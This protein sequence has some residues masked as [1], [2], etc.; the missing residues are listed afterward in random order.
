MDPEGIRQ[1]F[2]AECGDAPAFRLREALDSLPFP[3]RRYE[4]YF[5]G[6][7]LPLTDPLPK[8]L[9]TTLQQTVGLHL[10]DTIILADIDPVIFDADDLLNM[11]AYVEAG[12]GLL[13]LPG[14]HS[15]SR[16]QRNWGPVR[17]VL[18]ATIELQTQRRSKLWNDPFPTEAIADIVAVERGDPHLITRGLTGPL[19]QVR[20]QEP[21]C[22]AA[23]ASV[24]LRAGTD[25]VALAGTYGRGRVVMVTAIPGDESASLF[26]T[27]AWIDL[28]HQSL[29]W[30][31]GRDADLVIR[32]S[33]LDTA[34]MRPGD[35]R[36]CHLALE[37]ISAA[38]V[39]A[40][41]EISRADPGWAAVGREPQYSEPEVVE[42]ALHHPHSL[43]QTTAALS[44]VKQGSHARSTS[45]RDEG[46]YDEANHG[47]DY[48]FCAASPGLWRLRFV[49]EGPKWANTRIVEIPVRTA[50]HLQLWPET[51]EYSI[52]PEGVLR[53]QLAA[54]TPVTATIRVVDVEGQE[55]W[56]RAGVA[57]GLLA[58]EI[59]NWELGD[60]EVIAATADGE[61]ARLRF[62]VCE[63][64]TTLPFGLAGYLAGNTEERVRWWHD[65]FRSRGFNSFHARLPEVVTGPAVEFRAGAYARYIAQAG[66]AY[67]WSLEGANLIS[68]HGHYG[69]E[70]SQPTNPCVFAPDY[71]PVMRQKLADRFQCGNAVPRLAGIMILDE[72]HVMR[73]NVCRCDRCQEEF[74]RRHS[75][76]LPTWDEA[77][78]AKDGRTRDYFEWVVDY[79]GEAFRRGHQT[80]TRFGPGPRLF[81]NMSAIGSGGINVAHGIAEDLLWTPHTDILT[82][83]CYNYMY[84]YWRGSQQLMWNHFHYLMGHFRFLALRNHQPLGFWIQVTDRD[85][86][87]RPA[88]PLRAPSET[89]YTA[90][91]GGAK[92]F[93]LMYKIPFSNGQNCRE[94]KFEVFAS[95][96]RK[97]N[98]VAPLLERTE[99][100]RSRIA[101]VFPF[102][103]RLYRY[104]QPWLPP[105]HA[106]LGFYTKEWYP[107]DTIWPNHNAPINVAEL[108]VRAFGETDVIDQRALREGA[109]DDY[110]GFVLAG[111]EWM[112][113]RDAIAVRKFVERGGV[114]L[115]DHVPSRTL[116][117]QPLELLAPLFGQATELLYRETVVHRGQFGKGSTLLLSDDLNELYTS[118]IERSDLIL[119]YRLKDLVR[120]F[121]FG[122]G[123]RP[124][125]RT[126]DYQV[127]ANLLLAPDSLVVVAINH[128]G[129]RRQTRITLD[130]PPLEPRFAF[131]LVTMLPLSL[132]PIEGGV[133][134]DVNL[135]ERE[136]ML[137]GLYAEVPR[138]IALLPPSAPLRRGGR[139]HIE[140]ALNDETGTPVRGDHLVE[141]QVLDPYG[142]SYRRF[143]GLR[144]ASLGRLVLDEP[145]A[146]NA[147][148]G[149]WTVSAFDRFT[150]SQVSITVPVH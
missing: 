143:S 45:T 140:V 43:L 131:D 110:D 35:Q 60:Y 146:V 95:D 115:A 76:T 58:I 52:A 69:D 21:V 17:E 48:I 116:D 100:P 56:R 92:T 13:L 41:V 9:D 68:T 147:R 20:H 4:S 51:G 36:L 150:N 33:E 98:Q 112:D 105:G 15:F 42:L 16:A 136:G 88:D 145:L 96:I 55:I 121:F 91:G 93:H 128:A 108:L 44:P 94:E 26:Q 59:G 73:A 29:A 135:D 127:E 80:W 86:P 65:Y 14:P 5:F 79:V 132:E 148:V 6:V 107:M 8:R 124:H 144:C 123:L 61:E 137:V 27:A 49:V 129:N 67:L 46:Q 54:A 11:Q 38:P 97:V 40:R 32:D 149:D 57:D 50:R 74:H 19:G 139:F 53:L 87:V 134:F 122:A 63:P 18:P 2:F 117:D 81:L 78:A 119:R 85:I 31:M 37:P 114:L 71:E 142:V 111:V 25:P 125:A 103:D 3:A 34:P 28:L 130:H 113:E 133:A 138:Q 90:I 62:G 24:L 99:R 102:H 30:L 118:S 47:I 66:G 22:P 7:H 1:I 77:L 70:G 82:F 126:S 23:A 141:I 64:L 120:E 109:L 83:D 75:Y 10:Y 89:L 39:A 106:G 72:P 84:S 101:M 104:P 12:G